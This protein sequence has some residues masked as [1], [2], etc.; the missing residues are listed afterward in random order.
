MINYPTRG[1]RNIII[2]AAVAENGAIGLEGGL[3][4]VDQEDIEFFRKET[5]GHVVVMGSKTWESLPQKPLDGRTNIVLSKKLSEFTEGAIV[6]R[7]FEE[8]MWAIWEHSGPHDKI[9]IIG[10][11]EIYKMFLP[12]AR[13]VLLTMIK[14]APIADT[15]FPQLF[16]KAKHRAK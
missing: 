13:R 10:G 12:Y 11:L 14:G 15:Y 4:W 9:F 16:T 6:V 8:A 3:P 7:N 1:F 2:I 5:L